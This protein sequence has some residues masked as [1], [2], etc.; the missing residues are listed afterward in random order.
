VIGSNVGGI[1]D[2]ITDGENGFLVPEQ[3]P[4][5]LADR[6]VRIL[7]EPDIQEKFR[8]N[9]YVR[10]Q[11]SFTWDKIAEQFSKI[12]THIPDQKLSPESGDIS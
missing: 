6:I 11:E 4:G 7:S 9:G 5:A 2:I 3:D 10:I 1:P 12:Y 8:K